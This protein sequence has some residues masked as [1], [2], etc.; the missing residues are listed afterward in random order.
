MPGLKGECGE[1]GLPGA[2]GRDGLP[3]FPGLNGDNGMPGMPGPDAIRMSSLVCDS[4]NFQRYPVHP[5]IRAIRAQ[6]V[7]LVFPG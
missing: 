1:F 5:A 2:P 3:G 7:V 6:T 4:I